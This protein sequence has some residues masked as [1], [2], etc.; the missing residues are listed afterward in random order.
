M[1]DAEAI[2][3]KIASFSSWYHQIELAP[4]VV[5]PGINLSKV[6]L[7]RLNLPEDCRG[8]RALDIG[9]RDGYFSFELERRGAEVLAIDYAKPTDTGFAIAKEILG[10]KVVYKVANVY[11][12]RVEDYGKFDIVLFLGVLY[13]LRNPL[14]ALD[15]IWSVCR[16][17]LWVESHVLD[18]AFLRQ[19]NSPL[20]PLSEISPELLETPIMQFY[21]GAVLNNDAT[22]WWT[23]NMAC[24]R[25]MLNESNF[26]IEHES[27]MGLR[28]LFICKVNDDPEI[29]YYRQ[30]E[31]TFES[32]R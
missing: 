18:R 31:R 7:D 26:V 4:G 19:E 29:N 21:P 1:L 9:A 2:R 13:H 17:R 11:D 15:H 27:L 23:P 6:V 10:S 24:L 20:V 5:T 8:L 12:L 3:T 22:N 16:D 30:L 32:T 28:G 14:L 25:A